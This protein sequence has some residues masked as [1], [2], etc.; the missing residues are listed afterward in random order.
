MKTFDEWI[1]ETLDEMMFF[2]DTIA[3]ITGVYKA[4]PVNKAMSGRWNDTTDGYPPQ[5]LTALHIHLLTEA[6]RWL[7]ANQPEHLMIRFLR[8]ELATKTVGE[9]PQP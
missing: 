8:E 7:E 4:S 2:P 9:R 6:L 1:Y 3:S 5:L